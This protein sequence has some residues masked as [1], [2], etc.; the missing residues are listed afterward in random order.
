M[1]TYTA[2]VGRENAGRLAGLGLTDANASAVIEDIGEGSI[3]VN[4]VDPLRGRAV[5]TDAG[6]TD[7]EE[8]LQ[9]WLDGESYPLFD[10]VEAAV[11]DALGKQ[12]EFDEAKL[13]YDRAMGLRDAA[14]LTVVAAAG[15]TTHA[16]EL[17]SLDESVV[18]AI[19]AA[20]VPEGSTT[21]EPAPLTRPAPP[22]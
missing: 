13:A 1:T 12:T 17:L 10:D 20:S 11:A 7:D 4:D 3:R 9:I 15:S 14:V 21:E 16:A 5:D 6:L 18:A 2:Q 8:G 19:V 22:E